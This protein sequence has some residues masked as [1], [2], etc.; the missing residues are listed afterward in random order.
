MTPLFESVSKLFHRVF[1]CEAVLCR[2]AA[3]A[4]SAP[5]G[6]SGAVAVARGAAWRHGP[7]EKSLSQ[8]G[9]RYLRDSGAE[10]FSNPPTASCIPPP[11]PPLPPTRCS[12]QRRG[13]RTTQLPRK[14]LHNKTAC[15]SSTLLQPTPPNSHLP[16]RL[17]HPRRRSHSF[18]LLSSTSLPPRFSFFSHFHLVLLLLLLLLLLHPLRSPLFSLLSLSLSVF[19]AYS[20]TIHRRVLL[21]SSGFFLSFST[22][23]TSNRGGGGE[24]GGGGEQRKSIGYGVHLCARVTGS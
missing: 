20:L 13:A 17:F 22:E 7:A 9:C 12:V 6:D 23:P 10:A 19:W 4:F 16:L 3:A 1:V 2:A 24:E 8:N 15:T 14:L 5:V 21:F 11:P 18:L